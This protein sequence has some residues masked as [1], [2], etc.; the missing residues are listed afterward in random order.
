MF[1]RIIPIFTLSLSLMAGGFKDRYTG[2]LIR[3]YGPSSARTAT[4]LTVG[5]DSVTSDEETQEL[6]ALLAKDGPSAVLKRLEN[7]ERGALFT[8]RSLAVP[9]CFVRVQPLPDGKGKRIVGIT[10]RRIAFQE[11][12]HATRSLDYP[13]SV[14]ILDVDANGKGKGQ[15]LE[16]AMIAVGEDGKVEVTYITN[17]PARV[18]NVNHSNK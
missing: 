8:T 2:N 14:V 17:Q 5:I 1:R 16:A 11:T 9:L 13:W 18:S 7:V 4:T 12:W 10:A 6:R 15:L 3:P